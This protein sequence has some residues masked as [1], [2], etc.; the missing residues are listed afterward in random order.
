MF[1]TDGAHYIVAIVFVTFVALFI[2][3][4][5]AP[6]V[7]FGA[8]PALQA[9]RQIVATVN[10]E[11][12]LQGELLDEAGAQ[13]ILSDRAAADFNSDE[14]RRLLDEV[15]DQKLL[16]SE[17]VQRG[18]DNSEFGKRAIALARNRAL[19]EL[20]L[21]EEVQERVTDEV[22]R[23]LYDEQI[24]LTGPSQ[25]VKARHILLETKQDAEAIALRLAGGEDFVELAKASSIDS[26]SKQDG[27]DLGYFGRGQMV[28]TFEE[29]A[30]STQV[31]EISA[32]FESEFGWHIL[33]VED[34]RTRQVPSFEQLRPQILRY[35]TF[36]VVEKLIERLRKTADIDYNLPEG[37]SE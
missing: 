7:L 6:E 4:F 22:L 13:D 2:I 34:F 24:R 37:P 14:L 15:I 29:M 11:E 10:G 27:G 31:G 25:E 9:D 19:S 30:F 17:A 28:E 33:K 20:V 5:E 26:G 23:A 12:I 32:P 16:S 35:Q 3:W 21:R 36:Q 8:D 18:L 1:S